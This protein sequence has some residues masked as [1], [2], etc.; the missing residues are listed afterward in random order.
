LNDETRVR[1][2]KTF[3]SIVHAVE[4]YHNLPFVERDVRNYVSKQ[5]RAL[6]KEGDGQSLLK[7]LEISDHTTSINTNSYI[8]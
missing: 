4:G 3:Q 5:R 8:K 1:T 6:G 2:N 7:P